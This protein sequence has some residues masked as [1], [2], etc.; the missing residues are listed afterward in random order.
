MANNLNPSIKRWI[1]CPSPFGQIAV[2]EKDTAITN[3]FLSGVPI[4]QEG[5]CQQE[6]P[7]LLTAVCQ[8][9]EYFS[10]NRKDFSLP[11]APEGTAFQQA[12]WQ[13][14]LT[15]PYGH[16]KSY[17]EIAKEVGH[18]KA[19]RAVGLANKRNPIAI[20]IPCHRVIGSNKTLTGY[21]GGLHIKAALLELEHCF[22]KQ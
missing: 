20:F 2:A 4:P 15:I 6:T 10:G 19:Y 1:F 9:E 12:V 13:A 21:S 5:Y 17:G 11:L 14:L 16:T 3:L 22:N 8:L 7:L 18:P